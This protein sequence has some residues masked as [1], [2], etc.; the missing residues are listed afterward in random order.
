MANLYKRFPYLKEG[1]IGGGSALLILLLVFGGFAFSSETQKATPNAS[2]SASLSASPS[3]SPTPSPSPVKTCSVAK[4]ASN[5]SLGTLQAVVLNAS[6]GEVLFDRASETPASTASG[7]KTITAAAALL[8]LGPDYR[9][10]TRVFAEPSAK[11]SIALVG[12]GDV[13]LSKL[14]AGSQS[15]YRDAPKLSSLSK[16]V[17][18]WANS[19]GVN[20]ITDIILDASLFAGPTW[21]SSW[22]RDGQT[23][24]WISDVTSL[25]LDGDRVSPKFFTSPKTARPVTSAGEQFRALL[26]P[27]AVNATLS[28]AKTPSGFVEIASVKSQPMSRWISHILQSSENIESEALG[29]LVSVNQGFDGS[30]SSMDPAFKKALASTDLDL[31][32]IY[33]RDASGL[34][35]LNMVTPKF[36][37]ELMGLVN[38]GYEGFG[39]IKSNLP[40]S[41]KTGTLLGRFK[42]SLA[43]AAGKIIAKTGYIRE[44]YTLS[45]IINASDGTTLTF[46][47]FALDKVGADVRVAIDTLATGFYRCGNNLSNE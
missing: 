27:L 4:Q 18:D 47:I 37:A 41:G 40:I 29:R 45:G 34:S 30:F 32:N 24:G 2:P 6:T 10:T 19:N 33:I 23:D 3:P 11:T 21:E 16:Q 38:S 28:E 13:T 12:G 8:S 26:G 15:V 20:Q 42:G 44:A 35:N 43:D 7:M 39:L 5:P 25:Q 36:M 46:A 17:I 1:L 31:T 9:A 22:K 14:P